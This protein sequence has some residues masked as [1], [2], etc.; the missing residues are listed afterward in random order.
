[1]DCLS[2]GKSLGRSVLHIGEHAEEGESN[3][4]NRQGLSMPFSTPSFLLNNFTMRMLNSAL[5]NLHKKGG[6]T[7]TANYEGYF[8]P[9]DYIRTVSY[10]HLTLPTNREV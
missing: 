3:Y 10:T 7:Y 9:L 4:R 2:T 1:M 5:Y 6:E 8:F